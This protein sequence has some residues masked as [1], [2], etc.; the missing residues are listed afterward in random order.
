VNKKPALI[1]W[2]AF[3]KKYLTRED[4]YKY[5]WVKGEVEKTKRSRDKSQLYI[6]NNLMEF[7]LH[8]RLAGK[9]TGHLVAEPDLF[10]PDVHR[11]PDVAW[12]TTEQ[13]YKMSDGTNDIPAFVIEVISTHDQSIRVEKKM[14]NYRNAG[15]QVVWQI[16]PELKTVHVYSGPRL[17][18]MT[19]CTGEQI[20]SAASALPDFAMPVS[21]IFRKA[22]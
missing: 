3:Q 2:E 6:L 1:S 12:L 7:F 5:E 14:N 15:V 18:S 16:F 4:G 17:D 13:M 10:F 21:E 8:L 9:V 11:R 19:V 20:C 22:L